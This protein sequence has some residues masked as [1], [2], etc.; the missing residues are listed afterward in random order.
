[1]KKLFQN[2]ESPVT[3]FCCYA[4]ADEP[5]YRRLEKHLEELKQEGALA[6]WYS[7]QVVAGINWAT[8]ADPHINTA[9]IILLLL[10]PDLLRSDYCQ[11]FEMRRA[12]ERHTAKEASIFPLLLHVSDGIRERLTSSRI[13]P[14][15]I[16]PIPYSPEQDATFAHILQQLRLALADL[17]HILSRSSSLSPIPLWDIP[18]PPNE[19][20]TGQRDI[21]LHISTMFEIHSTREALPMCA[22]C[23]PHGSGKTEIALAYTYRFQNRYLSIFWADAETSTA[24]VFSFLRIAEQLNL[25]EKDAADKRI[26]VKAVIGWLASTTTWLLIFDHVSRPQLLQEF[27]PSVFQGHVLLITQAHHLEKSVCSLHIEP[28]SPQEGGDLLLRYRDASSRYA[29]LSEIT[30]EKRDLAEEIARE[31]EGL[32]LAVIQAAA[33]TVADG[34]SIGGYLNL[35]RRERRRQQKERDQAFAGAIH[36][37]SITVRNAIER[38]ERYDAAALEMLQICAFLF[39]RAIPE[40]VL[41]KGVA[42]AGPQTQRIAKKHAALKEEVE[43]LCDFALLDRDSSSQTVSIH[44]LVQALVKDTLDAETYRYWAERTIL[45]IN[46]TFPKRGAVTWQKCQRWFL[47]AL[48]CADLIESLGMMLPEAGSLLHRAGSYAG[49][50]GFSTEA[51]QLLRQALSIHEKILGREH[52][53]TQEAQLTLNHLLQ[54]INN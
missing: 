15:D 38:L 21:L 25:P 51:Q 44:P 52:P 27:L 14:V 43:W 3:L 34:Y 31:A 54:R 24:L 11:G 13:F 19:L 28:L 29:P 45:A 6:S 5:D 2:A 41:F 40:E 32:P 53:E 36:P 35:Y 49:E 16:Q 12:V 33:Y 4:K 17:P 20:F 48:A 46:K 23:G 10:S 7:R 50:F 39:P 22:L 8:V 37:V 18:S 9:S 42:Y 30:E 47:Q 1:M 26:T